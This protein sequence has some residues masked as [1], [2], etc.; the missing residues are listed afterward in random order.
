[1]HKLKTCSIKKQPK[2]LVHILNAKLEKGKRKKEEEENYASTI[3][4]YPS[5]GER[6]RERGREVTIGK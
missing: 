5:I 1:M 2:I 6:E 4:Q 3:V